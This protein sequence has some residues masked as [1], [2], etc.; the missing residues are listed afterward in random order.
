VVTLLLLAVAAWVFSWAIARPQPQLDGTLRVPG[1]LQPVTIIRD[2]RG[3]PHIHAHSDYDAFFAQGYVVAQDRLFQL[4]LLRRLVSGELAEVFGSPA[5]ASDSRHRRL[6]PRQ[7]ARRIYANMSP[8]ERSAVDAYTAGVNAAMAHEPLPIEFRLLLYRPKPW[9]TEDSVLAGL[10][11]VLELTHDWDAILAREQIDHLIGRSG[12]DALEPVSDPAYDVPLLGGAPAPVSCDPPVHAQPPKFGLRAEPPLALAQAPVEASNEWAVGGEHTVDGHALLANDPHLDYS[13]PGPW[14]LVELQTPDMHVTGAALPG[15][16]GVVLGHTDGIAWGVTSAT[17]STVTVYRDP[18]DAV[19]TVGR[20]DIAVRFSSPVEFADQV[21]RFVVDEEDGF[22][23]SA[24]WTTD[25]DGRLPIAALLALDHA[26]SIEQ[27]LR[28][29]ATFP[30]PALNFVLAERSG[31][32]AYHMVG[33]IPDDGVWSRYVVDGAQVAD[34]WHGYVPFDELPHVAP[35]RSAIVFTANNRVYGGAYP[36]RLTDYFVP[37]YRASR[38]HDVLESSGP[39]DVASMQRLQLD[40]LSLPEY[41]FAHGLADYLRQKPDESNDEHVIEWSLEGWDGRMTPESHVAT[42]VHQLLGSAVT[43]YATLVLGTDIGP[44]WRQNVGEPEATASLLCALRS[45][46]LTYHDLFPGFIGYEEPAPWGQVGSVTIHHPLHALGIPFF[47]APAF[48]GSGDFA[49]VKVQTP[50]HGQSFRAVWDVGS[51]DRGGIILP[52]GESG[53]PGSP[54]F[55]DEQ[56][57]FAEGN[58]LPL[59]YVDD[60]VGRAVLRLEPSDH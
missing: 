17:V 33:H 41:E 13:E 22:A 9:R 8:D 39:L 23:Y 59:L 56:E 6:R 38:I 35:S 3:V 34:A 47:D 28:A 10:E 46:A 40:D 50:T 16:P 5:V 24:Q 48:P 4:D 45:H 2:R 52:L 55:D 37:G 11:T 25:R 44:V 29:L 43:R 20:E 26:S 60:G 53:R 51:W 31:R 49:S 27:A 14:Y 1:L 57:A 21:T 12:A 18:V 19:R 7:L 36:F 42:L 32:V 58:I 30:G 54:Y 15:S